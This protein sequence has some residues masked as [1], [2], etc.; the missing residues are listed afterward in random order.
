[1]P[2]EQSGD[3]AG[4]E[5]VQLLARQRDHTVEQRGDPQRA[6]VMVLEAGHLGIGGTGGGH[7]RQRGDRQQ[8]G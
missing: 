2:V 3:L 7:G 5:T 1:M 4:V 6:D 8:G